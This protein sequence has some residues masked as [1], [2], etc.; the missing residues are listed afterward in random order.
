MLLLAYVDRSWVGQSILR[1]KLIAIIWRKTHGESSVHLGSSSA[2]AEFQE[3]K[4]E[5][6]KD[7]MPVEG[8]QGCAQI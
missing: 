2:P 6:Y 4:V 8:G 1:N 5:S 3:Y 7:L